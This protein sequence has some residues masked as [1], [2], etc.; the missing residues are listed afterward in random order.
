MNTAA[1]NDRVDELCAEGLSPIEI[2]GSFAD[3]GERV[4]AANIL[5]ALPDPPALLRHRIGTR[6]LV[7]YCASLALLGVVGLVNEYLAGKAWPLG[8]LGVAVNLSLAFGF[9]NQRG[10]AYGGLPLWL[11]C[12]F[13]ADVRQFG[14]AES[15]RPVSTVMIISF[16][17][18]AA[19][20][21]W[22]SYRIRRRAFPYAGLIGPRLD[23]SGQPKILAQ[24]DCG[25]SGRAV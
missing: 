11:L 17:L 25:T 22:L 5:S 14:P 16:Y 19:V 8:L 23:K 9:K 18:V 13:F 1:V 2:L 12:S 24:L 6:A 4:Q 10:W 20:F 7:I 15:T 21:A 3:R